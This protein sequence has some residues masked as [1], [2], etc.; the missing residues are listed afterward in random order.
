LPR[1]SAAELKGLTG[2]ALAL[3]SIL[4]AT[5]ARAEIGA[6]LT[7]ASQDRF[8]GYSVSNGYPAMTLSLSYDD[9]DGP[10]FE[11][12]VMAAGSP[13]E[14]VHR[15]R[16]EGNAGYALRLP[17]GPTIDAG[18]VHA[19]YS[20]YRIYG[21]RAVFTEFY[22]G[23]IAGRVSAHL[24]YAPDYFQRGVAVFYADID[25]SIALTSGVRAVAHAG[26]LR[27]TEGPR[28]QAGRL[29]HDWNVGA[30]ADVGRLSF[31][32]TLASG[33]KKRSFYGEARHGGTALI[34]SATAAF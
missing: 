1:L 18:I 20:G 23:L 27:Q 11:G 34:A 21:Q 33:S 4:A 13:A 26:M 8:R 7:L 29:T 31:Q 9:A 6:S 17:H 2:L 25:G 10:Y 16:F 32:L 3:G 19:D 14:G 12:S 15:Y 24:H 30:V 28:E 22:A 5:A